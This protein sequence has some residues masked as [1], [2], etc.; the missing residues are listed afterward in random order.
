M[1]DRMKLNDHI[2][3]G[4]QPSEEQLKQMAREGIKSVV[5][6]RTEGEEDQPFSPAVRRLT[7][8][9]MPSWAIFRS[10]SS[11]GWAPTEM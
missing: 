1:E 3:V 5:N 9:L 6:L 10:C 4:A 7:T 2:S 8:A 11:D